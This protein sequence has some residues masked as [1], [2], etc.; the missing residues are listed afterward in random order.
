MLLDS[1][2]NSLLINYLILLFPD[3]HS[4]ISYSLLFI[5]YSFPDISLSYDKVEFQINIFTNCLE[6][7]SYCNP[8]IQNVP[9]CCNV[10]CVK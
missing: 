9:M 6:I 4:H 10:K 1:A 5:L 7:S 3:K 2:T 8:S